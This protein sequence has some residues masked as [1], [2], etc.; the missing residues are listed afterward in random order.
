V[1]R[2][3]GEWAAASL[4][5]ALGV[6]LLMVPVAMLVMSFGPGLE[7]RSFVR[8]AAAEA[9]RSVVISDGDVATAMAQ[10][11][12]MAS[13]HG[14]P[15]GEVS[16]G[17]CG[18]SPAPLSAGGASACPPTLTRDDTVVATVVMEIP[19]VALP[20]TSAAGER[21]SVG[22]VSVSASHASYVDLYRSTGG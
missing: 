22:G 16:V 11:S 20:F 14:Y 4:E 8:L 2:S 17:L 18:A 10:V 21:A 3:Q 6:G 19:L 5:M 9:S 13:N 7:R 12:A 1:R 15:L